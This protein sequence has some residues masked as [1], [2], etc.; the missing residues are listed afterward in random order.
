[1]GV[2]NLDYYSAMMNGA[3]RSASK[4]LP[5][6]FDLVK[7]QSML[8]LGCGVGCWLNVANKLGVKR[9]YGFDGEYVNRTQL[10]I[11][12]G[13]FHAINLFNQMPEP[14]KVD[15]AI[16]L[17]V[18]EHLPEARADALVD[19]LTTCSDMVFFGAAIP[20]QGG[21]DHF[22]E[23]WQSYWARKFEA[24]GYLIST[25]LRDKLWMDKD[26]EVWYRQNTLLFVRPDS[27]PILKG[28]LKRSDELVLDV[29][30]PD[31]YT[32]KI[33]RYAFV[34]AILAKM[35]KLLNSARSIFRTS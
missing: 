13:D 4:V 33:S 9:V 22:N 10:R 19:F 1:M 23:Q 32:I 5:A 7:P 3:E 16:S 20:L 25:T 17:E 28:V 12:E 30:H 35:Q 34:E 26:I 8:D 6:L 31:L 27:K 11:N 18:A 2:Y 15:L 21:T 24:R 14:I 29:V